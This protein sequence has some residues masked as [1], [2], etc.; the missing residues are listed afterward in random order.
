MEV[1]AQ[2]GCEV[3]MEALREAHASLV[4]L[5]EQVTPDTT[6]KLTETRT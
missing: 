4:L 6:L 5:E 3:E 2:A 1:T